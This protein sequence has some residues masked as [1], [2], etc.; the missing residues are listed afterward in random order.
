[1]CRAFGG[2]NPSLDLRLGL[3]P[4][5]PPSASLSPVLDTLLIFDRN[6]PVPILAIMRWPPNPG[7]AFCEGIDAID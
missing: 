1:M 6:L 7:A 5:F 3:M 4:G 2:N